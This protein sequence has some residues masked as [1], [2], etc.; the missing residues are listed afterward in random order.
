[1]HKQVSFL[2]GIQRSGSTLLTKVLN[3][4][5]QMF[6][7]NTSPLFDYMFFAVEK[8]TELKRT[9]SAA[10][11]I[12]VDH[13]L[14]S[15]VDA[16]Y[17]FTD[18][19]HVLDKHRAWASNYTN[20]HQQVVA[21]PKMIVTLRPV[22]E[23]ITSFHTILNKN[24]T[25]ISIAQIYKDFLEE[26]I[27]TMIESAQFIDHLCIVEYDELTLHPT[28]TFERITKFL[29]LDPFT[30]NFGQIIDTDPEN[31]VKWG[32][33][34]LHAVRSSINVESIDPATIMTPAELQFFQKLTTRLYK[35]F[36][37]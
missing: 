20:V 26:H 29:E 9:S 28:E 12:D 17:N 36:K 2:S 18:K 4:H 32:I 14:R 25:P 22:E 13:I 8:L 23:V 6:A 31:D 34:N 1:M 11:Y 21:N 27:P 3:Q 7:S 16:F 10:H 33:K 30:F 37:R 5:P 15:T 19:P 24:G 35:A